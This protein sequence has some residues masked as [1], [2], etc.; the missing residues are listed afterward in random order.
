[1]LIG[2]KRLHGSYSRAGDFIYELAGNGHLDT[3][4][5]QLN[6]HRQL[7]KPYNFRWQNHWLVY[8]SNDWDASLSVIGCAHSI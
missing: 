4:K 6:K 1:M 7:T 3:V 2:T 5:K 8:E